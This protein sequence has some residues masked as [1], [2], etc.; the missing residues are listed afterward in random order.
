[1]F[2]R[3]PLLRSHHL[4]RLRQPTLTSLPP[5]LASSP[6]SLSPSHVDAAEEVSDTGVVRGG[7]FRISRTAGGEL[8]VYTEVR[9]GGG[10]KT[11]VRRVEVRG[12]FDLSV[13][14]GC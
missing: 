3:Q 13:Q 12:L 9:N 4:Q 8:P 6:A 2:P 5:S 11:I 7:T 1:M 10:W 14:G